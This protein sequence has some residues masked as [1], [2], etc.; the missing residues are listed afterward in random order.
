MNKLSNIALFL[1]AAAAATSCSETVDLRPFTEEKCPKKVK[2]DPDGGK[3]Y[4]G[5]SLFEDWS[6]TG[7]TQFT[8]YPS[9][10]KAGVA[11]NV[12]ISAPENKYIDAYWYWDCELTKYKTTRFEQD[13]AYHANFTN[14]GGTKTFT[15]HRNTSSWQITGIP[16]WLTVSPTSGS[17]STTDRDVTITA[18]QNLTGSARYCT[19]KYNGNDFYVYQG[20]DNIDIKE[21][22]TGNSYFFLFQDGEIGQSKELTITSTADWTISY[23]SY[24]PESWLNLSTKSGKAGTTKLTLSLKKSTY[25][26]STVIYFKIGDSVIKRIEIIAE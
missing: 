3:T 6:C 14:A 1:L 19:L 5:I 11:S 8:A 4:F 24:S 18:K 22:S 2:I 9:S 25:S 26:E 10:G 21:P 13:N 16:S 17:S 15:V 7:T 20:T 23:A 12:Y